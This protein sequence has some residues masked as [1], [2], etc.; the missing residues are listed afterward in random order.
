MNNGKTIY[1]VAVTTAL[2]GKTEE[3]E[4]VRYFDEYEDKDKDIQAIRE[5]QPILL[6]FSLTNEQI[7]VKI[8]EVLGRYGINEKIE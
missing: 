5:L 6:D 1:G 3:K 4:I 2:L 8:K 7:M